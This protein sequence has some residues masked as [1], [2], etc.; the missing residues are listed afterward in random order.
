[1]WAANT[2]QVTSTD[3][4]VVGPDDTGMQ[5]RSFVTHSFV[6][7]FLASLAVDFSG[8][9]RSTSRGMLLRAVTRVSLS[10]CLLHTH[11]CCSVQQAYIGYN[12]IAGGV[13]RQG[14]SGQIFTQI[15]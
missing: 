1:M 7:Q 9:G 8:P 15:R 2:T 12:T 6:L 4:E 3:T 11:C 13:L 5:V 10:V 14:L